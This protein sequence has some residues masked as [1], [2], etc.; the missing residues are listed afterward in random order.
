MKESKLFEVNYIYFG[1]LFLCLIGVHGYSLLLLKEISLA[2]LFITI[3]LQCFLEA[4]ILLTASLFIRNYCHNSLFYLFIAFSCVLLLAHEADFIMTRL[5]GVSIWFLLHLISYEIGDN[6]LEMIKSTNISFFFWLLGIFGVGAIFSIGLFFFHATDRLVKKRKLFISVKM[7]SLVFLI[8]LLVLVMWD[9]IALSKLSYLS[10]EQ[11]REILPFKTTFFAPS[12]YLISMDNSLK[13]LK[14]KDD[15][16]APSFTQKRPPIYLFVI[17]SLREDFITKE[18]APNLFQFKEENL[19]FDLAASGGNCSHQSWFTIFHSQ[20]PL[21]FS[22]EHVL[23]TQERGS[24]ALCAM[25]ELGYQIHLYSSAELAFYHMDKSIF[26]KGH[27]LADTY[28]E[29]PHGGEVTTAE[30]DR[31]AM[32][33]LQ[34]DQGKFIGDGHLF[35]IFL[36]ATHFGYSWPRD[37]GDKFQPVE[38]P[39]NYLK[40]AFNKG[41]VEGIKNRYRNAIYYVDSLI[42][43]FLESHVDDD[44]VILFTGD[45]GEAFY[46]NG[47]IFHA[48][49]L[50][51][52]QIHVPLYYKFGK[53]SPLLKT[54]ASKISSHID[55]FPTIIDY[56][57]EKDP[58][59][60][61]LEG[62][63]IFK[64]FRWPYTVTSR[65][66][67]GKAPVEFCLQSLE[68]RMVLQTH[69]PDTLK[70]TSINNQEN[71]IF[72]DQAKEAFS[73]LFSQD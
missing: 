62:E 10:Y 35:I 61:G 57:S 38:D 46:E 65:Y 70:V 6:F 32:E 63:S 69:I 48:S 59:L 15:Q 50:G 73:H 2:P 49:N 20:F 11:F 66:N 40:A 56:I 1:V 54:K 67:G 39:I 18:I 26:G 13:K 28:F 27:Q 60:L 37:K 36:D 33:Q 16:V 9:K 31:K 19:S 23:E 7:L 3:F 43:V 17:E 12:Q 51:Q 22:K 8:P 5:M 72:I 58:A 25:K 30:T 53:E 29:F 68:G 64:P 52:E 41:S 45:H 71:S 55:I 44:S 14:F 4:W 42:G 21:R 34:N 47:K 24:L